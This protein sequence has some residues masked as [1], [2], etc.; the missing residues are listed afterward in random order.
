MQTS[1]LDYV[2]FQVK[3]L[4]P[5]V[6]DIA[7]VASMLNPIGDGRNRLGD[8]QRGTAK[9]FDPPRSRIAPRG[10]RSRQRATPTSRYAARHALKI[11]ARSIL[12][13]SK[14]AVSERRTR[15][16]H[17]F[18]DRRTSRFEEMRLCVMHRN[19]R[20]AAKRFTPKGIRRR[21]SRDEAGSDRKAVGKRGAAD[22]AG[23]GGWLIHGRGPATARG[24]GRILP[25]GVASFYCSRCRVLKTSGQWPVASDQKKRTLAT[26][27]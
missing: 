25:G 15:R 1:F 6:E 24:G 12:G 13:L 27:H 14:T 11:L 22:R 23:R 9:I 2:V 19:Y 3:D 16:S 7:F 20:F 4:A 26:G 10:L 21:L 8:A 18:H 5:T 17:R